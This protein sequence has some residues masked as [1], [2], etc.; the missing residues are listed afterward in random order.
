MFKI[1]I[2]FWKF[3]PFNAFK[4]ELLAGGGQLLEY[5]HRAGPVASDEAARVADQGADL[6]RLGGGRARARVLGEVRVVGPG[7]LLHGVGGLELGVLE[8]QDLAVL[9]GH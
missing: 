6:A 8:Q 1:N 4:V 2:Y 3:N 7:E 9:R 5:E